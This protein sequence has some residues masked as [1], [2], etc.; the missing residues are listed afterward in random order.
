MH[1]D[2][3]ADVEWRAFDGIILNTTQRVLRTPAVIMDAVLGQGLALECYHLKLQEAAHVGAHL[4][5]RKTEQALAII[6]AL[7]DPAEK[8]RM[9]NHVFGSCCPTE[10]DATE[11]A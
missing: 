7:T 6:D 4:A 8:A 11:E 9:Y 5:N 3:S 10:Q 1:T 2:Q